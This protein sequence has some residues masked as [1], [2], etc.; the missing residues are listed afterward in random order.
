MMFAQ[1]H[2]FQKSERVKRVWDK[3]YECSACETVFSVAIFRT[4]KSMQCLREPLHCPFCM[5]S[6]NTLIRIH[7]SLP[8]RKTKA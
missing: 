7:K 6:G 8:D 3:M 4:P 5:V 1:E 2:V